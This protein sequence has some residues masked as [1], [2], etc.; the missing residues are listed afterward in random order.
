MK[1][2]KKV[3]ISKNIFL[4]VVISVLR[5]AFSFLN[6]GKFQQLLIRHSSFIFGFYSL[7][8]RQQIS[9]LYFARWYKKGK[10][11]HRTGKNLCVPPTSIPLI[12]NTYMQ[13]IIVKCDCLYLLYTKKKC[14]YCT[15]VFRWRKTA[16]T[17]VRKLS[18]YTKAVVDVELHSY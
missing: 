17:L 5:Q 12:S 13:T 3:K 15:S 4:F 9:C 11:N 7:L 14:R 18:G 6:W 8:H 1:W 2:V 10:T 16:A